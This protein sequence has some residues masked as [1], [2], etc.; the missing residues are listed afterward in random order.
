[1]GEADFVL[2]YSA[3]WDKD[4]IPPKPDEVPPEKLIAVDTSD[5]PMVVRPA[6]NIK[7]HA[8]WKRSWISKEFGSLKQFPM[9]R[10]SKPLFFWMYGVSEEFIPKHAPVPYSERKIE[11]LCPLRYD[12]KGAPRTI[13]QD[14]VRE[15]GAKLNLP[16]SKV[17][18]GVVSGGTR[19]KV[20]NTY[21]NW[22]SNAKIIVTANPNKWEGD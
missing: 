19:D 7:Y 2:W 13:V 5:H 14:W 8:L 15:A 16:K 18:A 4:Q 9:W 11:I 21:L 6:A 1:M 12:G 17:H 20:D 10:N 3:G 22:L